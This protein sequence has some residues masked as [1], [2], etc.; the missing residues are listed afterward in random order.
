MGA[1]SSLEISAIEISDHAG[2]AAIGLKIQHQDYEMNLV[3]D[4]EE[5]HQLTMLSDSQPGSVQIGSV[6]G[7]ATFWS[8]IN[9]RISILVGTDHESWDYGIW[10]DEQDLQEIVEQVERL[11]GD[12]F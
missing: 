3:L 8:N 4:Y 12:K 9:G 1:T 10:I 11:S 6:A 5:I 7:A 2:N